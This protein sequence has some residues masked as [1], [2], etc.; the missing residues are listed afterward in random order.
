MIDV[1]LVL[2]KT[3]G[4]QKAFSLSSGVTVIGRRHDCDLRIPLMAVSRKHCQ[5]NRDE[6]VLKIRDL[7]SRNGTYLNGKRID[8]A[9][10]HA[11][12]YIE[13]GPL[14]FV[15]RING[16]PKDIAEP[17]PAAQILSQESAST[18]DSAADDFDSFIELD[19]LDSLEDDSDS[20]LD[21]LDSLDDIDS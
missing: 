18:G 21:E 1:N 4:S 3:N 19:E 15:L 5:L 8:E 14:K 11:G 13:V 12:D 20:L 6:G 7:G 16:E 9:V 10:I 17:E 2:L